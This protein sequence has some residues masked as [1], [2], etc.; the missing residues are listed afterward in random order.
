MQTTLYKLVSLLDVSP[1]SLAG[2]SGKYSTIGLLLT[3]EK[4]NKKLYSVS[5]VLYIL[6]IPGEVLH[7]IG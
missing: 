6:I 5:S 3:P 1:G 7:E 2:M 4:A